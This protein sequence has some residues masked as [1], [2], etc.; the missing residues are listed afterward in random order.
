M[1]SWICEEALINYWYFIIRK[2]YGNVYGLKFLHLAH[3]QRYRHLKIF[4]NEIQTLKKILLYYVINLPNQPIQSNPI[5][6]SE[7]ESR[8]CKPSVVAQ[9]GQFLDQR[10]PQSLNDFSIRVQFL[11]FIQ[12]S[13]KITTYPLRIFPFFCS[14]T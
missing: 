4:K 2:I 13:L 12:P 8:R 6:Q 14:C 10:C 9:F 7:S 5:Q 1:T 11:K 3:F